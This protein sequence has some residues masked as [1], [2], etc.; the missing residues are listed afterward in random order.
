VARTLS[1]LN[2]LLALRPNFDRA[3]VRLDTLALLKR[4][5]DVVFNFTL[6]SL[7]ILSLVPVFWS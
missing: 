5:R 2:E 6:A 3:G 1:T 7:L 4:G